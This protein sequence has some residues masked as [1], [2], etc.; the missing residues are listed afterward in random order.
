MSIEQF[1]AS[2][3]QPKKSSPESL[4]KGAD[5][6]VDL[7]CR[8]FSIEG[9]ENLEE[10][11]KLRDENPDAHFVLTSSHFSNLDAPA[12]VKALGRDLDMQ[13]AVESMHFGLTPQEAMYRIAGKENFT[14]L[15]YVKNKS[16]EKGSVPG[17]FNPENFEALAEK[18]GAHGKN[19]WIALHPFNL[20][21]EME[22]AKV[23]PIYLAQK[24][25]SKI[26]PLALELSS[27]NSTLA[28]IGKLAKTLAQKPR[29]KLHIGK[30]MELPK[31][32]VAPFEAFL[33]KRQNRETISD[34]EHAA[35]KAA[36]SVLREQADLV[37]KTVASMLPAKMRGFY[38]KAEE[39]GDLSSDEAG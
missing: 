20:H 7:F 19:A 16:G 21:G 34:E 10:I 39:T 8:E 24:T 27:E 17:T 2:S 3:E 26:V 15:D 37:G 18:I 31:I 25:N 5:K 14:P 22:K 1:P 36:L 9:E 6:I 35:Y 13:I 38:L 23:G 30:P 4:Q 32:D 12:A 11:R 33:K 29:T 28:G